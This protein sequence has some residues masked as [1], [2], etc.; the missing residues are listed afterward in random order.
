MTEASRKALLAKFSRSGR[1]N[2]SDA[3]RLLETW[4]F[5]LRRSRRGHAVWVHSRRLTLTIPTERE[6]ATYYQSLV[7]RVISQL[8]FLDD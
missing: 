2:Y 6:L 4:E 7:V 8:Q 5:E 3:K 1:R